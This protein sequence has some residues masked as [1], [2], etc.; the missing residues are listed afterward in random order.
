MGILARNSTQV[1]FWAS[2]ADAG[3]IHCGCDCQV[4]WQIH[5]QTHRPAVARGQGR[6][7]GALFQGDKSNR[8][9]I[10]VGKSRC[11]YVALKIGDLLPDDEPQSRQLQNLPERMVWE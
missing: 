3:Q 6:T 11:L 5:F 7:A 4:S 10:L 2:R 1:W 8:D 9:S